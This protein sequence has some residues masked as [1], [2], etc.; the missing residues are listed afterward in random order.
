MGHYQSATPKR[1]YGYANSPVIHRIDRGKLQGWKNRGVKKVETAQKY[2]DKGGKDRYKG[3]PSL[4][5][6]ESRAA[7]FTICFL[8]I[9]ISPIYIYIYIYIYAGTHIMIF[10]HILMARITS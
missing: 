9:L 8:V 6:T 4:R 10:I 5:S 7:T 2:K 1:H 3:T